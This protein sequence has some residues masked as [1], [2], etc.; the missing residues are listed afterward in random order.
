[1]LRSDGP[2]LAASNADA[3]NFSQALC[4]GVSFSDWRIEKARRRKN[5]PK[6]VNR[7]KEL[8]VFL[9]QCKTEGCGRARD[10]RDAK[11]AGRFRQRVEVKQW[12]R[13]GTRSSR[14]IRG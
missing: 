14:Q 8:Q 10:S 13:I 5:Q 2:L 12:R 9:A 4:S 3:V 7:V 1:M 11:L 6:E